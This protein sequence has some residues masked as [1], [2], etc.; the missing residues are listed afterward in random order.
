MDIYQTAYQTTPPAPLQPL[1]PTLHVAYAPRLALVPDLVARRNT[2]P[3]TDLDLL[4]REI[5]ARMWWH[6]VH[7]DE[8]ARA[9][10]RYHRWR[11]PLTI[12]QATV[13]LAAIA[14][15]GYPINGNG[16]P[17]YEHVPH[18]HDYLD[19]CPV[20]GAERDR[21]LW[22][23]ARYWATA[24]AR[25]ITYVSLGDARGMIPRPV[26]YDQPGS[27]HPMQRASLTLGPE[28]DRGDECDSHGY[29]RRHTR[30]LVLV[31]A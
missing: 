11:S 19:L 29:M 20:R 18:T 10:L 21:V 28:R 14:E 31:R 23:A 30:R 27:M 7:P 9:T 15:A 13:V 26:Q 17:D 25:H 3:E 22:A 5:V 6:V 2:C 16:A 1:N 4:D 24:A 8:I 12:E